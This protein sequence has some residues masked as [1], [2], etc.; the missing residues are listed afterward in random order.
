MFAE[1]W[2]KDYAQR[3]MFESVNSAAKRISR[4][5]LRSRKQNTMFAEVGFKGRRLRRQG[6]GGRDRIRGFG[7]SKPMSDA[8]Q[9]SLALAGVYDGLDHRLSETEVQWTRAGFRVTGRFF[10]L[11]IRDA[12]F[13]VEE[14]VEYI[15]Y[16][17]AAFCIPRA[18]REQAREQYIATG[19]ERYPFEILDRAK[20]LFL[21]SPR[22]VETNGEP[23]EVALFTVL[24]G[25]EGCPQLAC[26][27]Y[28]KTNNEMP[29]HGTDGI[30]VRLPSDGEGLK[31]IWGESK[32]YESISSAFDAVCASLS[33]FVGTPE[34]PGLRQRDIRICRDHMNVPSG[35]TR[36]ALLKSLNPYCAEYNQTAEEYACFVAFTY[37]GCMC[38]AT[39]TP[40]QM[41]SDF[42]QQYHE[43]VRTAC[44]LFCDKLES[45]GLR[46]LRVRLYLLPMPDVAVFRKAFMRRLGGRHC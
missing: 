41:Q 42:L 3:W 40:E 46:T 14:F 9:I 18:D 35:A 29:V 31:L 24:E 44:E 27:M 6:V 5:T 34:M 30:H 21:K 38:D 28:L 7:L 32:I 2:L 19:D 25:K 15:Y 13:T 16:R 43:R 10:W 39:Q 20:S 33:Q 11:P 45:A 8:L 22:K 23:G 26:K 37:S 1:R 12:N 36:D 17:L 4:S